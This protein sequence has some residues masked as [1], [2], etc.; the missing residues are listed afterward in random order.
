[1]KKLAFVLALVSLALAGCG[2]TGSTTETTT[3]TAPAKLYF[4]RDSALVPVTV[5]IP[6]GNSGAAL[7]ALLAGPPTGYDTALP[8]DAKLESVTVADEVATARF[9]GMPDPTRS[10]QAQV[11][12]TLTQFPGVRKAEIEAEGGPVRLTDGAGKTVQPAVRADYVDLTPAALIFVEQPKRDSTVVSPVRANGTAVVFE[13]TLAVD[14]WSG[15][16]LVR[17]QTITA[18]TGG[19]QRGTWSATLPVPPGPAKLV[20]YEPSAADGSHLHTTEV[21]LQVSS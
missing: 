13:A 20:F 16:R 6:E 10:A 19:P 18:S 17:T 1:V 5:E 4:Y 3:A 21:F 9:S 8:K 12:Y 15:R 7:E 2:G 14:I 11:I